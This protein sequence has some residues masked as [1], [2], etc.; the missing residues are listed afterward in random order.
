[1]SRYGRER[2]RPWLKIL[3]IALIESHLLRRATAVQFTSKAEWE[4]AKSLGVAMRWVVLPLAVRAA[5]RS[6]DPDLVRG[7]AV[8]TG[9]T[10]LLY[11][12]RL[13]PKKNLESLLHAVAIIKA[14]RDDVALVIAGDGAP[15]YVK[16]LQE[17]AQSLGLEQDLVW[18]GRVDGG[19]KAAALAGADIFVLPS[20]SENFGIA[21]AEAMLAGLPS[22][23]GRG[24]AIAADAEAAG[25][26]IMVSPTADGIARALEALVADNKRREAMGRRARDFAEREFGM[27]AMARRLIDLYQLIGESNARILRKD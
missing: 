22:V 12:S 20:L 23:L 6:V 25:A 4:E 1:L 3:S 16:R 17:R 11:L 10:T 15:S 14:R 8:S 2:R 5:H 18:L 26:G 21:A 7:D 27:P 9:R 19:R 13:D 24:V